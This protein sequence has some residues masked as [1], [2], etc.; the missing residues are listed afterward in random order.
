MLF[1]ILAAVA[2][3]AGPLQASSAS[4]QAPATASTDT[5]VVYSGRAGQLTVRL[6]RIDGDVSVDGKLDEAVWRRAAV[7]ADFSQYA[8]VD[9]LPA[10]DSTEVRVWY[11]ASAI[12]FGIRAREPHGA[13]HA[14][15]ADR[16]HIDGDDYVSILLDTF[17]DGRRAFLFNVNPLGIQADGIRSEGAGNAGNAR[18]FSGIDLSPDFVFQS[19]GHVTAA[20]YEV[21][22]R[23]PFKSIR[24]QSARV[25]NWGIQIVRQVQHSG[26]QVTWTP[27]KQA[28][29][30][31]LAQG[32]TLEG[33]MELH[34]GLVLD[35]NPVA[36]TKIEGAPRAPLPGDVGATPLQ[37][38]GAEPGGRPRQHP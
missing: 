32:G 21:E 6:P 35:L 14:T 38:V 3:A 29:A 37:S 33:L 20:G 13:V 17:H 15:V 19:R 23:I 2:L 36:T 26:Y 12:Y 22:V 10:E 8:P 31:F 7:L 30:S 11:S 28:S 34:R 4:P 9:G 5:A 1:G 27:A 16:D 25:Q 24:Y 18:D